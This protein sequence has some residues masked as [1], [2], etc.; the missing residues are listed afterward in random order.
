MESSLFRVHVG[1]GS[2]WINKKRSNPG[3]PSGFT[4]QW[5]LKENLG[6]LLKRLRE[7]RDFLMGSLHWA[8][9]WGTLVSQSPKQSSDSGKKW[10]PK[11]KWL[12]Y[13]FDMF[14]FIYFV[15]TGVYT[16]T[17]TRPGACTGIRGQDVG[18]GS[19]LPACSSGPPNSGHQASR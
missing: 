10:A 11:F 14:A 1:G 2:L 7:K 18:V 19:L 5:R 6:F 15:H 12:V 9:L 8:P 16:C 13:N 17:R 4:A 3:A